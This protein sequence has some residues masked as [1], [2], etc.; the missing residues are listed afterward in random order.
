MGDLELTCAILAA[1][2]KANTER[3]F[4]YATIL[5]DAY[6]EIWQLREKNFEQKKTIELLKI[7]ALRK[8]EERSI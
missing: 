6:D 1:I 4:L 8:K 2:R 5:Q 7:G 3:Q